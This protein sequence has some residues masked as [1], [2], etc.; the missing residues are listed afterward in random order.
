MATSE[1]SF[2]LGK[3]SS[4]LA[5]YVTDMGNRVRLPIPV[6][7][8]LLTVVTP[9]LVNVGPLLLSGLRIF[10]I[11][12]VVPLGINLLRGK[13]GRI[14]VT[15]ILFGL[16]VAWAMIALIV[17]NPDRVVEFVGA[18]AVEFLGGYLIGRAYVRKKEDFVALIRL[19]VIIIVLLLPF[20]IFE[21]LTGRPP[22]IETI[23]K[24]PGVSS[25]GILDIYQ[26]MGLERVQAVF[27]HP[28]H[29]GL[30]CSAAFSFVMVGFRGIW[31]MT[32]RLIVGALIGLSVFLSLSSGALLP[33]ILQLF[34]IVWATV[35]RNFERRWLLL[36]G[37]FAFLYVAIDLGSNRT[38]L[39]VFFS[40]A[41]FSAHNAYWRGIIFEWGM[42]NVKGSPIF[43]IGL[44]DWVRP[45]FMR[46][47]SVDNFWLLNAMTYGI[48]GFL[49]LFSGFVVGVLRV[50]LR[51]FTGD[52]ILWQLR[53]AW[54]FCFI[55]LSFTLATVHIWTAVLSFVFFL[56]GAGM[57]F[58][59]ASDAQT[60]KGELPDNP[61]MTKRGMAFRHNQIGDEKRFSRDMHVAE[62]TVSVE[63]NRN[64]KSHV[65][66]EAPKYTR[67]DPND[68]RT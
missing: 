14:L 38:P 52:P 47:A 26:R 4:E 42:I 62:P 34:L 48:P 6:L 33:V 18:Y 30:F 29:Y 27:A 8:Y 1:Q 19:L 49:L 66:S 41:T 25:V 65:R 58:V 68:D 50:S 67:F 13:Y 20:A 57:W 15:D 56:Y 22:I 21:S 51:R 44:H 60:M 7:I 5:K 37:L 61:E 63:G 39:K 55:G 43:G 12:M 24:L 46:S 32:M 31:S 9:I 53:R 36:L 40:Y 64:G 2:D 54:V 11:I 59:T 23:R 35:F 17:N 10:L 16:Y 28:I 45:H 3:N